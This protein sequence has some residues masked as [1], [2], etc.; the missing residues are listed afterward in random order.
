MCYN[1]L[2]RAD[3]AL[4]EDEERREKVRN[5]MERE[6]PY[7]GGVEV[8]H[9]LEV[10][11]E[12]GWPKVTEPVERPLRGLRVAPYYGCLLLR[13]RGFG[14]DDLDAP[15][16]MEDLLE[17]LGAEVVETSLK[18][19]CCG[20]YHSV[21]LKEVAADL[22]WRILMEAVEAGA[23]VVTLACPL[24][25]FNMGPRQ[26]EMEKLFTDFKAIPVVYFTQLIALAYGLEEAT[27]FEENI[28]D[29]RPILRRRELI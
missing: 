14:I 21:H 15:R 2:K 4:K 7:G 11:R 6:A 5:I 20:A 29:P 13:P 1:T 22:S 27:A 24:C 17:A 28:P 26:R 23:D 9:L 16:A 3:R 12:L 8:V 10:I 18:A 25:E 19:R